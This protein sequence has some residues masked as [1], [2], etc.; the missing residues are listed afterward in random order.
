MKRI[1]ILENNDLER[2]LYE[3]EISE[4]GYEVI[5]AKNGRE[6]LEM[7]LAQ[8]PDLVITNLI[9][10]GMDGFNVI[11][12]LAELNPGLPVIILSAHGHSKASLRGW[13]AQAYITKSA[14]LTELKLAVKQI[15]SM[16]NQNKV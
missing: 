6:A 10:G 13:A 3:L 16:N 9:L 15:F 5:P 7:I 1:L 11:D 12:K 8:R 14:D 4:M 2:F